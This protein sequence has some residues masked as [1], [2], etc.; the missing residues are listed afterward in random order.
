MT[1]QKY[2]L[3]SYV[4]TWFWPTSPLCLLLILICVRIRTWRRKWQS[5][6][7]WN[8]SWTEEPGGLQSTR[9]QRVGHGLM[10]EHAHL[11][12]ISSMHRMG[13]G[14]WPW[15]SPLSIPQL[16]TSSVL[17]LLFGMM[18]THETWQPIKLHISLPKKHG[19]EPPDIMRL[20]QWWQHK[21][22]HMN[23]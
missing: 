8:S 22:L 21:E 15:F 5:I 7:A 17:P 18:S 23:C 3:I 6:P 12:F 14:Q 10:T 20:W 2:N 11:A 13:T 19:F 16:K 9:L 4:E 1:D